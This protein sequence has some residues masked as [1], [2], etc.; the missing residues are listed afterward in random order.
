MRALWLTSIKYT[1]QSKTFDQRFNEFTRLLGGS[2]LSQSAG[3]KFFS[4]DLF[5]CLL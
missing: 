3:F 4:C 5:R 1:F 2:I